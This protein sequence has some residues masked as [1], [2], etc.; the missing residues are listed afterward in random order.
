MGDRSRGTDLLLLSRS[1]VFARWGAGAG[2][3]ETR[4]RTRCK[5]GEYQS[6]LRD[7][8]WCKSK[9][10]VHL[11]IYFSGQML[12]HD[13]RFVERDPAG[14]GPSCKEGAA[15]GP[16]TYHSSSHQ[17]SLRVEAQG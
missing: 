17:R 8:A 10:P 2:V 3:L 9:R 12:F 16:F 11:E 13:R 4:S 7:A 5:R 6:R 1:I 15:M 14:T